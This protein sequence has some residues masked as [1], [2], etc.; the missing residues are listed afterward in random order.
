LFEK[1]LAKSSDLDAKTVARLKTDDEAL[2]V[3]GHRWVKQKLFGEML[4]RCSNRTGAS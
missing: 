1:G 2:L 4:S 3:F